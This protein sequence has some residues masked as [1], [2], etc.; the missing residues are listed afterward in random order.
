[1]LK[2]LAALLL[3]GL[4]SSQ[5]FPQQGNPAGAAASYR[6]HAVE[7]EPN[8]SNHA[9]SSSEDATEA[10]PVESKECT[11]GAG[12]VGSLRCH[13]CEAWAY[14]SLTTERAIAVFAGLLTLSTLLLWVFTMRAANAAKGAAKHIPAVERAYI[15][16]QPSD[17]GGFVGP[18]EKTVAFVE[19][20]NF[21]PTPG[22]LETLYGEF[23]P[24]QP[25]GTKPRYNPSKGTKFAVDD[26]IG[27]FDV[28]TPLDQRFEVPGVDPIYFFG[29]VEYRDIFKQR[30]TS[31]FCALLK[32]MKGTS[33]LAGERAWSSWD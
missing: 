4:W 13:A 28:P 3:L 20:Q 5:A 7:S 2:F 1:M 16:I 14:A 10:G 8:G 9:I 24:T 31:R 32:P 12:W 26:V 33:A 15:F 11:R 22:F 17:K 19:V 25:K 18:D 30:H 27:K 29:Y 21:G 23:S 6:K